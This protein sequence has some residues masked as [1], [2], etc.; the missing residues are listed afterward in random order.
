[1]HIDDKELNNFHNET[2]DSETLRA[3]LE[4]LENCDFCLDQMIHQEEEK[5]IAAPS[6]LKEQI[7]NKA[8]SPEVQVAKA[9][10]E[11]SRKMQML[12]YSLQTA[13]GVLA[14][15]FL[16]FSIG[17]I[18]LPIPSSHSEYNAQ[19]ENTQ[20]TTS[21]Q[22]GNRLYDFT[23]DIGQ[24]ITDNTGFVTDYLNEFSNKLLNGGK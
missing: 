17:S 24:T 16:L 21:K 4:H 8:S 3:F 6:Y 23:K 14:A 11:T 19:A 10:S 15:L 2:M 12:Y 20:E 7:L 18:E 9:A 5:C 22:R 1:M 13:A